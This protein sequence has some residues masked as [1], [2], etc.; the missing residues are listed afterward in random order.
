M[1]FSKK[2]QLGT[3]AKKES[4]FDKSVFNLPELLSMYH[5]K[6]FKNIF[7]QKMTVENSFHWLPV[8]EYA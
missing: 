2:I 5:D 7:N 1:E 8:S 4:L 3:V 6:T